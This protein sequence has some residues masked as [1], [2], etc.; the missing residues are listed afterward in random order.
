MGIAQYVDQTKH[1]NVKEL[2]ST[3]RQ[4]LGAL[5]WAHRTRPDVGYLIT[6][7]STDLVTART[8]ALKPMR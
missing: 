6:K 7:I 5:I 8:D 2:Q 1:T 4:G 3:F